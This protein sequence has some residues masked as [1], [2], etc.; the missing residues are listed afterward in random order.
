MKAFHASMVV[1]LALAPLLAAGS[2][3]AQQ[4]TE[5]ATLSP[6]EQEAGDRFKKGAEFFKQGDYKLALI[7]FER[8][9]ELVPNYRVLYN[10]GQVNYQLNNYAKAL[11]ALRRYLDEGGAEVPS[12][13]RT[14]VEQDIAQLRDRVASLTVKTNV[15]G[16]EILVDDLPLAK[17]PMA[18]PAVIDAGQHVVKVTAPA[19]EARSQ[20]ITVAGR[21][22][23]E[24]TIEI[25]DARSVVVIA[26]K[27]SKTPVPAIVAWSAT[28][29]FATAGMVTGILSLNSQ[30]T[31][32]GLRESTSYV[33]KSDMDSVASR[34]KTY[35]LIADIS[36]GAT[37]LAGGAALY[38]T[39][40]KE[41]KEPPKQ[42]VSAR[43]VGDGVA[44]TF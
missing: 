28:G 38:L 31:L 4:P 32:K 26:P 12:A 37:V 7:E 20:V 21:D 36:F 3:A 2:A 10:I 27:E 1:G 8:A 33:A 11:T 42:G 5:E 44:G 35:A 23:L 29:L 41:P 39:F 18:K 9:Y 22:N 19:H 40:R 16:A 15:E 14:A 17:A 43:F 30:S 6:R 13:R 24:I 25:R 34:A